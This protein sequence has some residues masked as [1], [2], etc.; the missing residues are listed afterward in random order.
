LGENKYKDLWSRN[1]KGRDHIEKLGV[2]WRIILN[3]IVNDY[4]VRMWLGIM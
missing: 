4:G 3:G 1:L 2:D